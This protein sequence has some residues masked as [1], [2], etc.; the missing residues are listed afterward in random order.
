MLFNAR[1]TIEQYQALQKAAGGG[2]PP[3]AAL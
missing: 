1:A 3:P 2:M